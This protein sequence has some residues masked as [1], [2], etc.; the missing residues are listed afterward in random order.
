MKKVKENIYEKFSDYSDPIRD[1]GIGIEHEVEKFV[2][3]KF[4]PGVKEVT[5]PWYKMFVCV[6]WQKPEFVQYLLSRY[7]YPKEKI[8]DFIRHNQQKKPPNQEVLKLLNDYYQ[9]LD[10]KFIEKSDPIRD[11][12][13]GLHQLWNKVNQ[14][15]HSPE[16]SCDEIYDKF[17]RNLICPKYR[18]LSVYLVRIPYHTIKKL[19]EN[20]DLIPQESFELTCSEEMR[21]NEP[22]YGKKLI[23]KLSSY[24]LENVFKL[25]VD[26]YIIDESLNEKFKETSDPLED[27]SIGVKHEYEKWLDEF[28]ASPRGLS[29]NLNIPNSQL[30]AVG[31][32]GKTEFVDYLINKLGA[33]PNFDNV[34]A[35]RCAAYQENF[36]TGVEL[37]KH[38][39]DLRKAI[40]H[41]DYW[42]HKDTV[43]AL[44][45]IEDMIKGSLNEKFEEEGDPLHTMGIG[46]KKIVIDWLND[47]NNVKVKDEQVSITKNGEI[48]F[49]GYLLFMHT[50]NFPDYIKFNQIT[51]NFEMHHNENFTSLEGFPKYVAGNL[52]FYNNAIKPTEEEIREICEVGGEIQLVDDW[53]FRQRKSR[54]KY[55][56]LGPI[57]S[58][59]SPAINY[60]DPKSPEYSQKYSRGYHLWKML[61]YIQKS[62]NQGRRYKEM[63]KFDDNFKGVTHPRRTLSTG[64][65]NSLKNYTD[66]DMRK[67]YHRYVLNH[68]GQFYIESYRK[69]FDDGIDYSQPKKNEGIEF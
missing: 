37:V 40:K 61:E 62:G 63:V 41:A 18:E 36:E 51:R 26:P 55:K 20:P 49:S 68:S 52:K 65:F 31:D 44:T 50:P 4:K 66:R 19:Q 28:K 29:W 32:Q 54:E 59:T 60:K 2:R 14:Q 10:E 33:N 1:M 7:Y 39:A 23:R 6:D 16:K 47:H 27:L 57:K 9:K 22:K 56:K 24:I 35:L 11:M 5:D 46:L 12:S 15:W 17:L 53:A 48:D 34:A 42:N 45:K 3:S 43:L 64:V 67:L 38:G 21:G 25:D 58:R 8:W 13:I 69:S 30:M